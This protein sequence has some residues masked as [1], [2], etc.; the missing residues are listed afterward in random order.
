MT[1]K[2]VKCNECACW[3]VL[4]S[5]TSGT[6][7]RKSPQTHDQIYSIWPLTAPNDFCCEGI[8][9][10]AEILTEGK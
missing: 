4:S 5:G 3:F 10:E 8:R 2:I 6:C 7:K 1:S 9:R